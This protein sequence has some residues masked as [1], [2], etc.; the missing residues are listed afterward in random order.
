MKL[1]R[2]SAEFFF[3]HNMGTAKPAFNA[4]LTYYRLMKGVIANMLEKQSLF[5]E[6]T[7]QHFFILYIVFYCV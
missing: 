2:F 6:D 5:S 7:E 3:L 1:V 4:T